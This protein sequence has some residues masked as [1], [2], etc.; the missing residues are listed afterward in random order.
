MG[1]GRNG[2]NRRGRISA[3]RRGVVSE[4]QLLNRA[5]R[6]L[7]PA[8]QQAVNDAYQAGK[9]A[10]AT[11]A[12]RI[13]AQNRELQAILTPVMRAAPPGTVG[14]TIPVLDAFTRGYTEASLAEPIPGMEEFYATR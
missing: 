14:A 6:N 8:T 3:A 7:T 9:N 12:P 2:G 4:R 1:R 5:Y 10:F 11:G 13:P